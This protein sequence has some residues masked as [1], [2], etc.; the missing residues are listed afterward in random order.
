M[1]TKFVNEKMVVEHPS[2]VINY[3]DEKHLRGL[4]DIEQQSIQSSQ[5]FIKQIQGDI[6]AI[7]QSEV[8][9]GT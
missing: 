6:L 5:E 4:I 7:Q 8:K 1:I 2:G 9:N 3:Y